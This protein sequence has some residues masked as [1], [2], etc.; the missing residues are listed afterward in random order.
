MLPEHLQLAQRLNSPQTRDEALSKLNSD[1]TQ[2]VADLL[3]PVLP[4]LTLPT[5][6]SLRGVPDLGLDTQLSS[7][8]DFQRDWVTSPE[9][10]V[11]LRNEYLVRVFPKD[12]GEAWGEVKEGMEQVAEKM[13]DEV[14]QGMVLEA[15]K[16]DMEGGK[17]CANLD[18]FKAGLDEM[19]GGLFKNVD[20]S[21]VMLGGGSVLA[22]LTG[23]QKD[24]AYSGSDF[25]LFLYGHKPE[26]LIP[27]VSS[28][29]DQ[30][31]LALPPTGKT[32]MTMYDWETGKRQTVEVATDSKEYLDEHQFEWE[33]QHPG[34]TLILKGFNA[35]SLVPPRG[36]S[37]RKVI[38]IVLVSN[39]S[40]FDSLAP[41]DLDACC[42]GWTGTQVVAIP[43]AARALSFGG[44]TA[45]VNLFDTKLARKLDPTSATV[46]SRALKYLTRGFSL[47][48]PQPALALL[49]EQDIDLA[50]S[51]QRYADR[52]VKKLEREKIKTEEL[53][54]LE[55][56]MRRKYNKEQGIGHKEAQGA[57]YGPT[58]M[59]T[60]KL[61]GATE[62][63]Y[64][65][66]G[67]MQHEFW[68]FNVKLGGELHKLV[69]N[70]SDDFAKSKAPR[71]MSLRT[72][73]I[74]YIPGFDKELLLGMKDADEAKESYAWSKIQHLQYIT[75]L[76]RNLLP[77]VEKADK[78]MKALLATSK[79][80]DGSASPSKKAKADE[81]APAP[82][83][84]PADHAK[85]K[86]A[87]E[88]VSSVAVPDGEPNGRDFYPASSSAALEPF[89]PGSYPKQFTSTDR[90]GFSYGLG[91]GRSSG[92]AKADAEKKKKKAKEEEEDKAD[93]A[94]SFI[95]P[96]LE[97]NGVEIAETKKTAKGVWRVAT[98][99]G[100]WAWK[101]LDEEIDRVRDAVWQ[102]W[103]LTSRAAVSL[104]S[105]IPMF[106]LADAGTN[107]WEYPDPDSVDLAA[108]YRKST[109]ARRD[110]L[111][112]YMQQPAAEDVLAQMKGELEKLER[113]VAR[114]VKGAA[115]SVGVW[116]EDRARFLAQWVKGEEM[117]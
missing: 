103:V 88:L 104:P 96:L 9:C 91:F 93:E 98:L 74:P 20:W 22:L 2:P 78:K 53:A 6:L 30:I 79:A 86:K 61:V 23:K 89:V 39:K 81:D 36:T 25:D 28:L 31:R 57:D 42:V 26:E 84:A 46:S 44:W 77:L 69:G 106:L 87:L 12:G 82:T 7:I 62:L 4:Y 66:N 83:L 94:P 43:R 54:G 63:K 112:R 38:Q 85:V 27:K 110:A 3:R 73:A 68:E 99:G 1:P 117:I 14:K 109:G 21:N 56:L 114:P 40:L 13:K 97:R 51:V 34:E 45:G 113:Q 102:A 19:S 15:K 10:P 5:L 65:D 60:M 49:K 41:F 29:I 67:T 59:S 48:L 50:K 70:T 111:T 18:E 11:E 37:Q 76:P 8:L 100:L 16:E 32:T 47:A 75:L 58:T 17:V 105:G 108:V 24:K 35:I 71:A 55:G 90:A 33:S 115:M 116:D 107:M 80:E 95:A 64:W 72:Y 101:G 92:S 52:A